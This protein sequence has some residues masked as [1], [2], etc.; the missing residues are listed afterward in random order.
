MISTNNDNG[1]N[2]SNN[3]DDDDDDDDDDG[4]CPSIFFLKSNLS[5]NGSIDC[6]SNFN[7]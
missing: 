2:N 1:N 7:E 3:D 5:P 6:P 4:T